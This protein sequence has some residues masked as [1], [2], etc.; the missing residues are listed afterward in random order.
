MI[1][2]IAQVTRLE[3][4]PRLFGAFGAVFG[5][6]SIIGP[7]IG[8]SLTDH[9]SLSFYFLFLIF[10]HLANDRSLG[11]GSSLHFSRVHRP[12]TLSFSILALV[13]FFIN[14]PIGGVS[15]LAVTLLLKSS[16]PLGADPTQRS[17]RELLR[18]A[19]WLDFV[20]ATLVAGAVTCLVLALQWGGNTKPWNDRAVIIVG[21]CSCH[22]F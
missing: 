10:S 1:Q 21:C 19:L 2:I 22:S 11:W 6:S 4:R 20:G 18:Q 12:I 14:L 17:P 13:C 9:A 7:L 5:L 15:L 3:D 8:G 16:P